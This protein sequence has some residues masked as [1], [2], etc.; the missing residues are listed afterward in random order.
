MVKCAGGRP[1][2]S[3]CCLYLQL[4]H[5]VFLSYAVQKKL[6]V[7]EYVDK[8]VGILARNSAE[9]LAITEVVLRPEIRFSGDTRP[10]NEEIELIHHLAHEEC[11]IT[12]SV[13]TQIRVEVS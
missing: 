13:N 11:F 2:G 8:A 1:G 10:A 9:K 12:N 3:F 5:V 6:I 4:P 7:D